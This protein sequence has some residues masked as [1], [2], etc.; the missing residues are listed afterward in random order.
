MTAKYTDFQSHHTSDEMRKVTYWIIS[1]M[2]LPGHAF[3]AN[4]LNG[5]DLLE[6]CNTQLDIVCIGYI[7]AVAYAMN[8]GNAVNGFK[9]CIPLGVTARQ[10]KDIAVRYLIKRPAAPNYV[11][12]N[13]VA[14]A[15][16]Q[17]FP[18]R[19]SFLHRAAGPCHRVHSA[20]CGRLRSY[21]G[22]EHQHSA[23]SQRRPNAEGR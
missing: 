16:S 21:P 8:D 6:K 5:N 17:A 7:N 19:S 2:L 3:T 4:F 20:D 13:L 12:S 10:I 1:C 11:A 9:A 15:L 23:I 22:G 14:A 18:C